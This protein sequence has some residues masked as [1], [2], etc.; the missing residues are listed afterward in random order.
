MF[1]M[2]KKWKAILIAL[3]MLPMVVFFNGCNC[4]GNGYDEDGLNSYSVMFYT[5]SSDSDSFNYETQIVKHG[6]TVTRPKDPTR[7][8]YNFAGWYK[9][10]E[11]T[12]TWK[13]N[14]DKVYDTTTIYAKW[15]EIESHSN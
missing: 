10:K 14:E 2:K 3:F 4:K 15:I 5:Y 7:S 11:L 1:R 13:F 6:H 9:D 8:G 12:I